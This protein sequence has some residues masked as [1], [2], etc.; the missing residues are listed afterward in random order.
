MTRR[1]D[2]PERIMAVLDRAATQAFAWGR[3]DCF[4]LAMDAVAAITGADPYPDERGA[5]T[6]PVGARL[7]LT[8]HGFADMAALFDSVAAEIPV[9]F[10]G[11]GDL[12]LTETATGE[13]A[14]IVCDGTAWVGRSEGEGFVRVPRNAA[15]RAWRIG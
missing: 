10:A 1:H 7:R 6:T 15:V 13:L 14:A 3:A 5:Y 12:G 11:R 9:A 2:W 8:A 4:T